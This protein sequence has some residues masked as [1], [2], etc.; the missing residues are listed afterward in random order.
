M[1]Y[2]VSRQRR[3][4]QRIVNEFL[5]QAKVAEDDKRKRSGRELSRKEGR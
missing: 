1:R 2:D 3:E 5:H 4:V